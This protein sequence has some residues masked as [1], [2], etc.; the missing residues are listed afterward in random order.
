MP[1]DRRSPDLG[2]WIPEEIHATFRQSSG[3]G[4]DYDVDET[5]RFASGVARVIRRREARDETQE[6]PKALSVFLLSPDPDDS[7]DLHQEPMLDAGLTTVAGKI[8]YVNASVVRGKAMDLD[9]EEAE[10]VFRKVTHNLGLGDVPA[11]VV[12]PRQTQTEV[13]YY[14]TGLNNPDEYEPVRLNCSDIDLLQ[15]CEAI[16]R[17]YSQSLKTPS[18]QPSATK[19]WSDASRYRPCRDAE[20][21]VEALIKAGLATKFNSCVV[22]HE[23]SGI[24]GRADIQIE[25]H[26][27]LNRENPTMLAVIE[28]KVLRSYSETGLS[29]SESNAEYCIEEG[30]RQAWSYRNERGH[31]LALLCCFDMRRNDT[32]GQCFDFVEDVA[33]KLEV[34][35]RRW[36]LYSSSRLAREAEFLIATSSV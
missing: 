17:V 26:D 25:E 4:S 31:R 10:G 29:Y 9:V 24:M 2:G 15:I 12:D 21:K 13:R 11:A 34:A 7:A 1:D 16:D 14:P 8:W 33:N 18:A 5:I 23:V 28:L 19:L 27:P 3:A 36:Y 35:L 30:V 22:S 20:D 32:G 6:D